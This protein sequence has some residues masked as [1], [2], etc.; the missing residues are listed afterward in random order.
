MTQLQWANLYQLTENAEVGAGVDARRESLA[1]DAKN[2]GT[3]H[4]LA[5]E[6]RDT[7]GLFAS[8]QYMLI[9]GHLSLESV[10]TSMISMTTIQHG[11]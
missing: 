2:Y 11:H 10:M 9:V 3:S 8:G 1:D 6:S 4:K 5:G 7:Q